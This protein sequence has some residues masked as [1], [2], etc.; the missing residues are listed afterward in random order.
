VSANVLKHLSGEKDTLTVRRD[1]QEVGA[2]PHLW[3]RS[4]P[5][6]SNFIKPKAPYIFTAL[7][8]SDFLQRVA[9]TKT[10]I[11]F[12]STLSKHMGEKRLASTKSHD[13]HVLL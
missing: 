4:I 9:S 6:S 13:H 3:L 5:G 7:E 2:T 8:N 1:M 10:P 12:S 11:G